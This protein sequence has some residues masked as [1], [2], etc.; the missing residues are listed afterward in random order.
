VPP[1]A[2]Q[3][4]SETS[5]EEWTRAPDPHQLNLL[6]NIESPEASPLTILLYHGPANLSMPNFGVARRLLTAAAIGAMIDALAITV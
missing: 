3:S 1:A 6:N 2:R 4:E 5:F